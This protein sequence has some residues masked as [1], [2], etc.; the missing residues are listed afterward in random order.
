[1][2]EPHETVP[3]KGGDYEEGMQKHSLAPRTHALCSFERP[4]VE[5]SAASDLGLLK[6]LNWPP[7]FSVDSKPAM[8][9]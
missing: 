8:L 5:T 6:P 3:G 2:R 1:M 4:V 9:A 7:P